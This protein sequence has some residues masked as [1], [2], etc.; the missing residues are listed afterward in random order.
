MGCP[1]HR[2]AAT[3]GGHRGAGVLDSVNGHAGS[4]FGNLLI[5]VVKNTS[6]RTMIAHSA[7]GYRRD[8]RGSRGWPEVLLGLC[9]PS[10]IPVGH[11]QDICGIQLVA[12]TDTFVVEPLAEQ[13][14]Q[15]RA[16]GTLIDV[17]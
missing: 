12:H 15:S 6:V 4:W 13:F 2:S 1:S 10:Q 16:E 11:P 3:P 8:Y 14:G 17:R 9:G 7:S 5:R